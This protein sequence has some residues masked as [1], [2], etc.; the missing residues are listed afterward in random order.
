MR[1]AWSEVETCLETRFPTAATANIGA[2]SRA[3]DPTRLGVASQA[4][5]AFPRPQTHRALNEVSA[6]IPFSKRA[7]K[8]MKAS[9]MYRDRDFDLQQEFPLQQE[10]LM[11]D[12]E[13]STLLDSMAHGDKVFSK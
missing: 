12:L 4:P 2:T 9:L 11:R 5:F 6:D 7:H 3:P 1:W 13:V 8:I 10:A